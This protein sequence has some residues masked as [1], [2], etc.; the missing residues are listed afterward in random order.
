[1]IKISEKGKELIR[2]SEGIG[3]E[4]Y[5]CP[6]KVWTIGYGH[7]AGVKKGMFITKE[8]A[9]IYLNEDLLPIESYLTLADLDL[10]QNQYDAIAS[11]MFN[12]GINAFSKSTLLRRIKEGDEKEIRK[13]FALSVH[14]GTTVL[15]G[16]VKRRALETELFFSKE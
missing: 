13:Q 9:D 15:P 2:N 7:T 6:A 16:L 3:Y 4:S 11:F 10:N 1:M 5:L 8:Q 14:A 12:L